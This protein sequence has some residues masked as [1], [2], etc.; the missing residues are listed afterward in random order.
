MELSAFSLRV[1]GFPAP[2]MTLLY[3]I[4]TEATVALEDDELRSLER[5]LECPAETQ[6][7]DAIAD[8]VEAL[9]DPDVGLLV[10]SRQEEERDFRAWYQMRREST[11]VLSV[12]VSTSFACNFG[13]TYCYQD[14]YLAGDVMRDETADALAAW[15]GQRV[16]E[17]GAD[18]LHFNV[19]GG[20]PLLHPDLVERLARASQDAARAAGAEFSFALITNGS[21]LTPAIVDRLLPLGLSAIQVTLDGD[22][23][24][25]GL[26]RPAKRGQDTFD[27]VWRNLVAVRG[28]VRLSIAGNYTDATIEGFPRLLGALRRAGFTGEDVLRVAWKPAL[29]TSDSPLAGACGGTW[30]ESNG[31]A[32]LWLRDAIREAGY[33]ATSLLDVGPCGIHNENHFA[34]DPAGLLFECPGFVGHPDWA[35]GDVRQGIVPVQRA[36]SRPDDPISECGGCGWRS[37]CAGGCLA[38]RWVAEGRAAGLNCEARYYDQVAEGGAQRAFAA[39]LPEA[40]RVQLMARLQEAARPVRQP[41][42]R[43]LPVVV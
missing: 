27:A 21:L 19:L 38:N 24:T 13:C 26:T 34:V 31:G 8:L 4:R 40:E 2:G 37:T 42:R 5:W 16:R 18:R 9:A 23:A 14:A 10:E 1:P 25:H 28:R 20:E 30:A 12:S 6:C 3:A 15:C 11:K 41:A 39:T 29:Q 22:A 32:R 36:K 43:R 35:I 33:E 7:P 17:T